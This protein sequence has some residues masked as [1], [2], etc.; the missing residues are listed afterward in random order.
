MYMNTEWVALSLDV[1][2]RAYV[3]ELSGQGA[4]THWGNATPDSVM[5]CSSR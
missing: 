2:V 5:S 3:T 1:P 4:D